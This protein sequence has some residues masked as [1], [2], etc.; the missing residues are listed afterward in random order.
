MDLRCNAFVI[1]ECDDKS[2]KNC[3]FPLIQLKRCI[4]EV[5]ITLNCIYY[6]IELHIF[7]DNYMWLNSYLYKKGSALNQC[8]STFTSCS[9]T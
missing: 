6:D 5:A 2:L 3:K 4:S 9:D 8:T 7:C 1:N